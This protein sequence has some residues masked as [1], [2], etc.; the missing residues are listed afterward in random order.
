MIDISLSRL[1][2]RDLYTFSKRIRELIV[3]YDAEALGIKIYTDKLI[4]KM[5]YY[6][7]S[8]EKQTVT[9]QEVAQKVALRGNYFVALRTH[10]RNYMYHPDAILRQTANKVLAIL[11]KYGKSI[12]N[13]GYNVESAAYSAIFTELDKDYIEAMN[14]LTATMWY[15][16]LKE[17]QTDFES[18]VKN[19]TEEKAESDKIVS[20]SEARKELEDAIRR[21]FTFLPLQYEMT[22]APELSDLIGQ[23]QVAADRF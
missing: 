23:L 18:T 12:Y 19:V 10:I 5:D 16:F 20:A 2:T 3:A 11:N 14:Q 22:Q 9:A 21:F 17:A 6:D 4:Q 13:E 8:F 7:T 15:N 1:G